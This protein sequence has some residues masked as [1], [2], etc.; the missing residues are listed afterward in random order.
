MLFQQQNFSIQMN[1][2]YLS[3]LPFYSSK[4]NSWMEK[5]S[6]HFENTE[7]IEDLL[8]TKILV[9]WLLLEYSLIYHSL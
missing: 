1:Q 9:L 6:L 3:E 2:M 5:W 4:Q 7:Q 8:K